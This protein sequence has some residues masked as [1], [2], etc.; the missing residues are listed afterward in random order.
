MKKTLILGASTNPERYAYLAAQRLQNHGHPIVPVG[1]KKGVVLGHAIINEK[2][3][4]EGIDTITLYIAP[5]HQIEWYGYIL[6]TKP[7][8]IIFNPGTENLELQQLA[9]ENGIET[10]DACTLVMLSIGQY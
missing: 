3:V 5:T 10:L 2:I 7:K 4:Q 1:I 6:E 9:T 8:R